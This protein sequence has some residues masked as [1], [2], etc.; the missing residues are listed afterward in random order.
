MSS[1]LIKRANFLIAWVLVAFLVVIGGMTWDRISAASDARG[2]TEHS[3]QVMA[4]ARQLG[5][6][7]RDA[8]S[9]Q[10]GYLL[11][12]SEDYLAP[13]AAAQPRI[14]TLLDRLRQLT[15]DNSTEQE[16]LRELGPLINEKLGELAHTIELRRDVGVA[17]ALA[18][19]NSDLGRHDMERA[20]TLLSAMTDDEQNLLSARLA[21]AARRAETVRILVA[22]GSLLAIGSLIWAA[23]LLNMAWRRSA[24]AEAEQRVLA[25]R[26]NTALDSL[27]QGVGVFGPQ[28]GLRHWNTCFQVLLDVPAA[29]LRVGVPYAALGDLTD[30]NGHPLL[31][32]EDQLRYGAQLGHEP[33]VYERRHCSGHQLEIRRTPMPDGGFV[34]TLSD[35][36]GRAQA[37][38]VLREAQKMQAIGQLT[39]GIAHDFNNLLQGITGDPGQP[40]IRSCQA[41]AG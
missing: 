18:E 39:G 34:L 17:A 41:G 5:I 36:T 38:A 28:R 2:W 8:E 13:Y 9:G 21:E 10:R 26:L 24:Q 40:R 15:V 27:S 16:R 19:V 7:L 20:E 33:I 25:L 31:E 30:E 1:Y 6:E 29:T 3:Y 35:M 22:F 11:T 23:W 4:T 12:G 32:T 14:G 37:E